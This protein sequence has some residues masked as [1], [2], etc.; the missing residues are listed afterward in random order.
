MKVLIQTLV[1][2]KKKR[3]D[4]GRGNNFLIRTP[5]AQEIIPS[6]DK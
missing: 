2:S 4:V 3:K 6:I 5:V 1:P